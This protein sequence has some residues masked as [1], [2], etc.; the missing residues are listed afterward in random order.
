MWAGSMAILVLQYFVRWPVMYMLGDLLGIGGLVSTL[1]EVNAETIAVNI[2]A[3]MS[4][5]MV[6]VILYSTINMMFHFWPDKRGRL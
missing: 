1:N 2:G 5:A 6:V 3:V 4:L